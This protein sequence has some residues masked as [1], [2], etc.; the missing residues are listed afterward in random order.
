[1]DINFEDM[2]QNI[3]MSGLN[4]TSNIVQTPQKKN[5]SNNKNNNNVLGHDLSYLT[6]GEAISSRRKLK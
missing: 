5:N 2:N 6:G 4:D 1:M 3:S